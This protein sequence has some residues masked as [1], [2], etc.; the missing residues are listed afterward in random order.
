M[1][2][3][4]GVLKFG[5]KA[6]GF[7]GGNSI[8][9]TLTRT[10]LLGYA[11]N[12]L[13]QSALK[14]ND[15]GTNNIDKGVRLQ[16]SPDAET[17]IPVLYGTA[18]FGGNII[19]AAMT[20]AN[21]TMWYCLVLSEKTGSK[22]SDSGASSYTFKDVYWNR[23]RI[24]FKSDGITA[25][26]AVDTGG[27]VDRS[28][29]GLVK[30][31][32]YNNGSSNG[33]VP[34]GYSG[35][36]PDADTL[37]P[38]W[39]SSTHPMTDLVFALVKVDYNREK[40]VTGI[41]DMLFEIQNSMHKPG[42]VIYDYLTNDV[43]GCNIDA[44]E[45]KTADITALNTYSATSVNYTDQG[46]GSAT[47]ANR[48]QI[49]GVIDTAN[50]V[51]EN[52]EKILTAS[53]SYLSYDTHE[54]QWGIVINK[55]ETSS[56]SFSD[57][58]ILGNIQIGGTGLQ[59]LYNSVKV[60][61]PHRDL[62]DSA[63]FVKIE[64]PSGDLNANEPTN[65]LN[66]NYDIINEPVQAEVLGFI[67]L[68]QS[69]VD[70]V[71]QF[72]TDFSYINLKAGDV[73]DITNDRYSFTNKLFRIITITERQD[74]N[75][76]LTM[77]ITAL[78]YDSDVYSTQN[79]T[80][81]TRSDDDGIITIGSIGTPGT[82]QV[83]KYE[84]DAR[85]RIEIETTTPTGVVE[86][87]EFWITFDYQETNDDL[88]SYTLVGT[89]RPVGGGTYTSGTTVVFEY[90]NLDA[91]N[92]FVKVR[93]INTT[94]TGQF[95]SV[96][97][98]ITFDPTQVPNAIT[99]DTDILDET[100]AL[101]T[102]L[103]VV[104]LL[105]NLDDLFGGDTTSSLF[106]K[107]FE[108]FEDTT[109]ID[110]IDFFTG[111]DIDANEEAFGLYNTTISG[112]LLS[113]T[114]PISGETFTVTEFTIDGTT[115]T[116]PTTATVTGTGAYTIALNGDWSFTPETDYVG[117]VFAVTYKVESTN[118][119]DTSQLTITEIL[120]PANIE[121]WQAVAKTTE[122]VNIQGVC[123]EQITSMTFQRPNGARIKLITTIETP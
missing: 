3:L 117:T 29:S 115:Y 74:T 116:T 19:D 68:K 82:P 32:L 10:A 63:D 48:Y 88:R 53:G 21:K 28:I 33:A 18:F 100:G 119:E 70:L 57:D 52:A 101:A 106:D 45:I 81:Y 34:T 56:A 50:N 16:Y 64:I 17:K 9:S 5:K 114:D 38:N 87:I 93:G 123:V 91:E 11:V 96:S 39:G 98:L 55:A 24:V 4:S 25:D 95:S 43:Y 7:L 36:V 77:N 54:G 89:K 14:G 109:G 20:N 26:Y 69:R 107:V 94:T 83:T 22:Y 118:Y 27:Q 122:T 40:N 61:F 67:E 58:N 102:A 75:G 2:F 42:D 120:D 66:I 86:G 90:D 97:G 85:P 47:L 113:N 78:E 13:S 31:Y 62:R 108:T 103:G 44:A 35:S 99:P 110:L 65:T 79:I 41:A 92:F 12:K 71:V 59:D 76:A 112:N 60:A 23:Q 37:F 51:L 104:N 8:A 111:G 72:E 80:R 15:L 46:T 6:V 49:N 30:I 1:S 84:V 105:N 73:I 121:D